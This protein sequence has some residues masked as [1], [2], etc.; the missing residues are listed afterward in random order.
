[1]QVAARAVAEEVFRRARSYLAAWAVRRPGPACPNCVC[2]GNGDAAE[3]EVPASDPC[4]IWWPGLALLT[5]VAG[6][7]AW[8]GWSLSRN[9]PAELAQRAAAAALPRAPS[10]GTQEAL[11]EVTA[12]ER[13]AAHTAEAKRLARRLASARSLVV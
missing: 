2:P 3:P 12:L 1:M 5:F 10:R 6:I 13:R 7:A 8:A 9:R 11:A 4:L